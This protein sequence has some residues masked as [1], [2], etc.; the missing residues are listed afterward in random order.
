[1]AT[2]RWSHSQIPAG[3][4]YIKK[5]GNSLVLGKERTALSKAVR[6]QN[7][8]GERGLSQIDFS[9]GPKRGKDV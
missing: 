1:M 5:P 3:P 7:S 2:L 4:G 6:K 8:R 9:T